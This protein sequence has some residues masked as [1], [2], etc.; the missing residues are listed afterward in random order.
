[1]ADKLDIVFHEMSDKVVAELKSHNSAMY[2]RLANKVEEMDRL[3]D[4]IKNIKAEI[5][6]MVKQNIADLFAAEHVTKTRIVDTVSF[7]MTLSKD[8]KPTE[9]YQYAKIIEALSEHLTPELIMI[10]EDIKSKYKTV[11]QKEPSL[12]VQR[13]EDLKESYLDKIKGHLRKFRTFVES[14]ATGYDK[15]LFDLKKMAKA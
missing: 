1:M 14:W 7:I 10:L 4:E 12:K 13:K 11:T 5:K 3:S 9:T 8:P 6:T 2:T 15:K